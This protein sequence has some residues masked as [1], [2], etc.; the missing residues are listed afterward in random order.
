ME[1]KAGEE[2]T[3]RKNKRRRRGKNKHKE[4]KQTYE[5]YLQ[6]TGART[7]HT[8]G[9]EKNNHKTQTHKL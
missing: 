9:L 2:K 8:R 7:L 4:N 3:N 1:N 5:Y 6:Q